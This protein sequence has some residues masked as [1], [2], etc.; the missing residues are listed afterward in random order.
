MAIPSAQAAVHEWKNVLSRADGSYPEGLRSEEASRRHRL[1]G[2]NEL[3]GKEPDPLWKKYMEQ[4]KEPLILLLLGSAA[5]SLLMGQYDDALSITIAIV[6]VVTVAFVQEY[7]SEQALEALNSLVPHKCVLVRDGLKSGRMATE[8]VVG[9]LVA[10]SV[11]DRIPADAR[12]IEAV[13]LEVD[14]SNLTG[15]TTARSKHA[16]VLDENAAIQLADRRNMVFMGTLVRRGRGV[17]VVT[18]TAD[19]TEFGIIFKMLDDVEERRTPLQQSM[20]KLGQQLSIMS[21]AVIGVIMMIGLLQGRPLVKMFAI[22]VSLAVAAIPEGLPIV[23]TVTLALGVMRMAKRNAIVKRLPAVEALGSATVVCSDKTGTLTENKMTARKLFTLGNERHADA[24][25]SGYNPSSGV[26]EQEGLQITSTAIDTPLERLMLASLVCNNAALQGDDVMGSPTEGALLVLGLKFGLGSVAKAINR[27]DERPFSSETKWMAVQCQ[28]KGVD[29]LW[30]VKGA[31]S[32]LLPKCKYVYTGDNTTRPITSQD[33]ATIE[34]QAEKYALDGF[35]VLM[36]SQGPSLDQQAIIGIVAIADHPRAGVKHAIA[37]LQSSGVAVCMITG[38]M[39][40]TAEAIAKS[41]G[42]FDVKKHR[43]L[44]GVQLEEMDQMEL[45]RIINDVRVFYRTSPKN[46]MKIVQAFQ[47]NGHV[48]AMTGDGVNDAPAL[49]LA[50][51][52]VAMGQSGTEVA[53][54]AADMILVDD[55][56]STIMRAIEEGKGIAHNVRNFLRFQLSTSVAA[57]SLISISTIMGTHSPL[58]AM[59][60]LWINILMDGPPAQSLGVEPVQPDVMKQPP[61]KVQEPMLNRKLFV[62]VLVAAGIIVTGV[63]FVYKREMQDDVVTA[64][65]TTMTFTCFVLFDMFTALT[66]RSADKSVF[67][68]GLFANTVFLYAVGASLLGQ[69]AVIYFPP[70]QVVFQTEAL[71]LGDIVYLTVLTSSVLVVDEFR[72]YARRHNLFGGN[73][74][75]KR[76]SSDVIV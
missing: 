59:Q 65:D 25:G 3:T 63:L 2:P 44:S 64:R 53:K 66:C 35:R 58:N 61:R 45:D 72:K 42:F 69:V 24:T 37:T 5:I 68:L 33:I 14:E 31:S 40:A 34:A 57:L 41:L 62:N 50:E 70:L 49:K 30:F 67:E 38:D 74:H 51:I 19:N 28:G 8:V 46:K 18:A 7:K 1:H 56:F 54:E 16:N 26:I 75:H 36:L 27:V 6:I 32:V 71:S 21:F 23:V 13:D 39:Q 15:E 73:S 48:V 10:F 43:S 20:E 29:N 22:A 76:K 9:D 12:L 47:H 4:F 55:D 52:G 11:G 60:I 17:A